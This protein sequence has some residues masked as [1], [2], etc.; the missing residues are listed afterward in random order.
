MTGAPPPEHGRALRERRLLR[1]LAWVA[2]AL[3]VGLLA[4]ALR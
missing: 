1:A 2:A 3:L 4:F